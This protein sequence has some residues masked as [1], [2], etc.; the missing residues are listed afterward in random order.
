MRMPDCDA[1]GGGRMA[2]EES[3]R[4]ERAAVLLHGWCCDRSYLAP[5]RAALAATHRVIA[6]DLPGHGTNDAPR[7]DYGVPAL[8][9]DVAWLCDRLGLER[10]LLIGHSLGGAIAIEMAVERP[11]RVAAAVALDTTIGPAP[12]TRRA[13]AALLDALAGPDF[14]AA[15]RD[16]IG[17]LYFLPSD[18]AARRERIIAAMTALPQHVMRDGFAGIAAWDSERAVAALRVPFLHIARS[19]GGT[20][21]AHLRQLCRRAHTGRVVGSGHFVQLEVPDQVNAMIG[22]FV[23]LI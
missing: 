20:D 19:L 3:G 14:R 4:G 21:H 18:D 6:I 5:Q 22:R 7:R 12:E 8:A 9:A 17:R 23:E 15:A 13:W 11:Q 10:P 2:W 16:A 1:P